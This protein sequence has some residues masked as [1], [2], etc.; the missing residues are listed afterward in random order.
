MILNRILVMQHNNDDKM[1]H[2]KL[3]SA[4]FYDRPS[5]TMK[6]VFYFIKK[7]DFVLEIFKFLYFFPFFSTLSRFKRANENGIIYDVIN[8][9]A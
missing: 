8:W 3:V 6:N 7:A 1:I 5:K 2:L 4:T 9:L